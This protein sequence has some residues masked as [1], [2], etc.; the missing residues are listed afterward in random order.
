MIQGNGKTMINLKM[1]LLN[2]RNEKESVYAELTLQQFY[3]L[4]HELKRAHTLME[5]V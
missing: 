4:F 2:Q 3:S 1:D 5:V